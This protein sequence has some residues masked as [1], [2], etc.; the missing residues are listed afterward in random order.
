MVGFSYRRVPALALAKR[1]VDDGRIGRIHHIRADYLQDWIVDPEF[2]LVWRLQKDKAG[3][4]A[5]GD[6]G[7][8]VVDM[9]YF[10][11]GEKLTGVAGMLDTFVSERPVPSASTGLS[12]SGGTERGQVTVDD[13]ATFFG[14]T[15]SGAMASFEATR[16]ATGRKN[17]IRMELNGSR[18]SL[19][20]DFERMN[21]LR[22][23][24]QHRRS[25]QTR[26]S[27]GSSRPS[28]T[29]R[30]S[31]PGGRPAMDSATSTR[32]CTRSPTS[33]ATSPR[34][35]PRPRRSPTACTSSGCSTP[36]SA[37]RQTSP[38]WTELG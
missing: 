33:S 15:E 26:D 14:R 8:H 1:L 2:P 22:G 5:L 9:A 10:L 3:S 31:A 34:A 32:S 7:A 30:T 13:A 16:F 19:A 17:A 11:T 27:A 24:R 18:G 28:P 20:F 4:G 12:A 37:R 23:L 6:I 21:E 38:Q 29:I 25:R 36:S 35:R